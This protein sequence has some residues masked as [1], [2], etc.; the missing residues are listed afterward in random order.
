MAHQT[1]RYAEQSTKTHSVRAR[2]TKAADER[3]LATLCGE[4]CEPEEAYQHQGAAVLK[5]D[6]FVTLK[7][8]IRHRVIEE[9]T[10]NLNQNR[11]LLYST[12]D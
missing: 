5:D 3:Q 1:N 2:T 9:K 11:P 8:L 12:I 7:F 6:R 4:K 10:R